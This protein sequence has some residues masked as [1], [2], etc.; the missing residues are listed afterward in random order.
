M[1]RPRDDLGER[2]SAYL[3]GEVTPAERAELDALVASNKKAKQLLADLRA[4]RDAVAALPRAVAPRDITDAIT[5]RLERQ[6]LLGAPG[7]GDSPHTHVSRAW[8]AWSAAAALIVVAVGAG[9][10]M[11]GNHGGA[12]GPAVVT[13]LDVK[14]TEPPKLIL[15]SAPGVPGA[16]SRE[17]GEALHDA[18]AT[19]AQPADH[20][21][22]ESAAEAD[23]SAKLYSKKTAD[24]VAGR[25]NTAAGALGGRQADDG[26]TLEQKLAAG[27]DVDCVAEHRFENEPL[28][29]RVEFTASTQQAEFTRELRATLARN[30]VTPVMPEQRNQFKERAANQSAANSL[31][32]YEG[33][34]VSN[35]MPSAPGEQQVLVRLPAEVLP[36][37]VEMAQAGAS[38]VNLEVGGIRADDS[39]GVRELAMQTAG[40]DDEPAS[41]LETGEAQNAP[42]GALADDA[43]D[44]QRE[45]SGDVLDVL[46]KL[47]FP[48]PTPSKPV[49]AAA[50]TKDTDEAQDAVAEASPSSD[51][52]RGGGGENTA[53][54]A[55]G[56]GGGAQGMAGEAGEGKSKEMPAAPAPS[57]L[58]EG[59]GKQADAPQFDQRNAARNRRRQ[60]QFNR[61]QQ[62]NL[63]EPAPLTLVIDM[64]PTAA[65]KTEPPAATTNGPPPVP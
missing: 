52:F 46:A 24:G 62:Q 9:L 43:D 56:P 60:Q 7:E 13:T 22:T 47:G 12:T 18:L 63:A 20:S 10:Y 6:A 42:A 8:R 38:R 61:A 31:V 37:V 29:L 36:E 4:T 30:Q 55:P 58:P 54:P 28:Q 15:K 17:L 2:L 64:K 3:D 14:P 19:T 32:Y 11:T 53:P 39:R 45:E 26:R 44:A 50:S 65:D 51:R 5:A 49:A 25:V 21:A 27:E 33:S 59:A 23:A 48:V 57:Q 41:E 35:Y 16:P 1:K 40:A 34:P